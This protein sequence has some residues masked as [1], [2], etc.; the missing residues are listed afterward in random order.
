V[1]IGSGVWQESLALLGFSMRKLTSDR[2][3]SRIG[4]LGGTLI[5]GLAFYLAIKVLI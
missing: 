2:I 5:V 1:L 3:R 4:V